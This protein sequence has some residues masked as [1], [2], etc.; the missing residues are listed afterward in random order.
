M[1]ENR[2]DISAILTAHAEGTTVGVSFRSMLAAVSVARGA[3][4]D[5]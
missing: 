2:P 5:G 1:A 4:L 3:D